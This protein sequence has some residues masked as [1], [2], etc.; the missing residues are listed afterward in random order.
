MSDIFIIK[1]VLIPSLLACLPILWLMYNNWK[2]IFIR[3]TLS[4]KSIVIFLICCSLLTWSYYSVWSIL[5]G[6]S[7]QEDWGPGNVITLGLVLVQMLP[8]IISL[9]LSI[10]VVRNEKHKKR[11]MPLGVINE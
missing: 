6:P 11:L 9:P 7:S 2:H 4:I 8:L 1:F 3:D 10:Y 5:Y